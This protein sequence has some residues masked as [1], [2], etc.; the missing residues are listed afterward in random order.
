MTELQDKLYR[1][2][3]PKFLRQLEE[4]LIENKTGYFV[5]NKLT[6]A[7]LAVYST[8]ENPFRDF[9][10]MYTKF[11]Q[12]VNNRKKVGSQPQLAA[13]LSSRKLTDM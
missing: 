12:V 13:Y 4:L 5:G 7:D 10:N 1:E 2:D 3:L 8:L 6:L 11:P 9:P